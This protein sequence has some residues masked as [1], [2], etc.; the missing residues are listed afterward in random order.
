MTGD[1][2]QITANRNELLFVPLG[3]AGEIG[4]NLNLFGHAGQWLMVDLGVTFGDDSAP[5]I[6]VVMPDPQFIIE[7]RDR[8]AGLVL[9]HAHEDHIGAVP[10]LWS[11]LRCPM[12]ATPF[13]ASVLRR[14]LQEV[15]L[16]DE[17]RI[18]EVPSE[19]SF[20][21]GPFSIDLITL[22]HSIPEP[23]ALVIR[24][25]AGAVFHTGD[26]KFD[27]TPLIGAP[28]DEGAL[29]ALGDAGI[30]ALI[31]DSTNVFREGSS[32][33]EAAVRESLIK[34]VARCEER[35]AIAC[36]ASN[37]A[38]LETVAAV[39]AANNRRAA[40]VG[41]SLWR[42]YDA[43]RENGYLTEIAPFLTEE[44]A[45][46]LPREEVLLA[47]TGSQGEPRAALARIAA[48][49]HPHIVL[50]PGDTVV[51]SSRIIPGNERA[52]ARVHNALV[53]CGVEVIS[54]R[55]EFIHVSGHPARDE[56]VRMY[57][58][59]RPHIA[60][61]V[62]GEPRHLLEHAKLAKDCQVPE[63]VVALNGDVV[64]LAP[65]KAEIVGNVPSGRLAADGTILVPLEGPS[66]QMRR[67]LMFNGSA[68]ATLVLDGAG[69]MLAP[70]Q[71]TLHGIADE[72]EEGEL[73]RTVAAAVRSAVEELP[74]PHRRDDAAVRE[75]AR[76]A[77]RRS[78]RTSRGKKPP[79]DIHIVR[80][81]QAPA[82]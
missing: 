27:P 82:A 53:H 16:A 34:L 39:A 69:E 17:A 61:P 46:F 10:Y 51:F 76:L 33:S 58:L 79:I 60:V 57:Q 71:V 43:A 9:T 5:G 3:G 1:A 26:W 70:P 11:R 63:T 48:G 24:T 2:D 25:P 21:V 67:R 7:R 19:G 72:A 45:G 31:G 6:D 62:H 42:M 80:L 18:T 47:V 50:E 75:A 28:A 13:T 40:L 35:V 14:K 73:A 29:A 38:R 54:E 81:S 77:V 52:I 66:V 55:D 32:G 15:G 36:F 20:T 74:R 78:V 37:V 49:D 68:V 12:Y 65:G 44:E 23:N 4:M 41:R 22:T 8:L 64:R 59:I 30:L 56:L